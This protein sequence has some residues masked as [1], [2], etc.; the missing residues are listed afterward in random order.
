MNF[1]NVPRADKTVKAAFIPKLDAFLFADYKQIELRLLAYYMSVL[2]DDSMAAHIRAGEDLHR[3]SAIGAFR[4]TGEP[5]DEERQIGK[6]L[7]FLIVYGGGVG[8]IMKELGVSYQEAK[9]IF[10][11]FHAQWP[12]IKLVQTVIADRMQERGYVTTLFGRHL[13]PDSEHKALNALIQGCAADL[14]K[15][16][17]VD[18]DRWLYERSLES[19][20][21]SVIHDEVIFDCL[22]SEIPYLVPALPDLMRD[23]RINDV[24]PIEVD[25]EISHTTWAEK[26]AYTG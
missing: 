9:A 14:M 6:M 21:V 4:L 18:I 17:L 2:G 15:A 20:M 24:V 1:Q 10:D 5:T 26:E 19:H 23:D 11:G 8:K 7:N 13:H 12:G 25:I 16:S 22:G 3:A